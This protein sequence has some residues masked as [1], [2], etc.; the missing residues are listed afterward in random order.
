MAWYAHRPR[1]VRTHGHV[2]VRVPPRQRSG[3]TCGAGRGLSLAATRFSIS[4]CGITNAEAVGRSIESC[5]L[6]AHS[7]IIRPQLSFGVRPSTSQ[8]RR[9]DRPRGPK[10]PY[11]HGSLG[12]ATS[13]CRPPDPVEEFQSHE[14]PED[15]A[16]KRLRQLA[17]VM[18][19]PRHER[20][21]GTE[22]AV[23][24]TARAPLKK[25]GEGCEP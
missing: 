4:T 17:V 12:A 5:A 9:P 14:E 23:G 25:R 18:H 10:P 11:A 8:S 21:V 6:R 1:S 19:R 3:R 15:R 16:A 2:A 7:Y 24:E 20:A 13:A 22:P